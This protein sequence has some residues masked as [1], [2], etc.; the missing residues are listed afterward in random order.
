MALASQSARNTTSSRVY[1]S[2]RGGT[3]RSRRLSRKRRLLGISILAIGG[4]LIAV[5]FM[6]SAPDEAGASAAPGE[7]GTQ[8]AEE[9]RA[10]AASDDTRLTDANSP[11]APLPAVAGAALPSSF[12]ARDSQIASTNPPPSTN[13]AP[14]PVVLTM[15]NPILATSAQRG[16]STFSTTNQAPSSPIASPPGNATP[17]H[18]GA[19]GAVNALMADAENALASNE[20]LVARLLLNRAL[21]DSR[22]GEAQRREI[23]ARLTALNEE[24]VFSLRILEGDPLVTRY[25]VQPGDTLAKIVEKEQLQVDWRLIQRINQ[26][27]DPRRIRVGQSL[28]LVR[29]PFSAVI[30]KGEFRLDLYASIGSA[31]SASSSSES[32]LYIRSFDVGLGLDGS[33][34]TGAWIVRKNSKLINPPWTNPQNGQHFGA[35]NPANPIGERWIGLEGADELTRPLQG[36]GIHGTIDPHSI[37]RQASMGCVRLQPDDV[38]IMYEALAEGV[39]HVEILP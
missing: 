36:Y 17:T 4:V 31:S 39:S 15:G 37:G 21:H 1:S 26:I 6:R 32:Q 35:D 29:G 19:G 22:A 33:T 23:R 27:S 28:K 18:S 16:N 3:S 30:N 34:P 20:P 13:A 11:A 10:G 38:A 7:P 9:Q 12:T 5:L 8:S 25:V 14:E 24:L 2:R